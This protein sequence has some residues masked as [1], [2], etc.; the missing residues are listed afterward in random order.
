LTSHLKSNALQQRAGVERA[1]KTALEEIR[2]E[3]KS[4]GSY[5]HNKGR[6]SQAEIL[7][8][9]GNV[10]KKTLRAPYHVA[11]RDLVSGF[12]NA[13]NPKSAKKLQPP[14]QGRGAWKG[15]Y[16][17]ETL[18]QALVAAQILRDEAISHVE[19]AGKSD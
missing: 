14:V 7:R 8:R 18:A 15:G 12:V 9:A 13:H 3:I 4:Y 19:N 6:V 1:V 5:P 11:L 10:D 16:D 2:E 17:L